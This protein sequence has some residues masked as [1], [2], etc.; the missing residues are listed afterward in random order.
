M[1]EPRPHDPFAPAQTLALPV[2]RLERAGVDE[3]AREHL[4]AY[5]AELPVRG[6]RDLVQSIVRTSDTAIRARFVTERGD[7]QLARL[8]NPQLHD[9]L[10]ARGLPISGKKDELVER[11]LASFGEEPADPAATDPAADG[12]Q[13]GEQAGEQPA[14]ATQ[15]GLGDPDP[16]EDPDPASETPEASTDAAGSTTDP[17][18][19]APAGSTAA[20]QED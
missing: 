13:A 9:R 16:A 11:L 7:E 20:T 4:A 15:D 17:E 14:E 3:A 1:S 19:A 5:F 10:R 8:T 2:A 12:E 18:P 6:R